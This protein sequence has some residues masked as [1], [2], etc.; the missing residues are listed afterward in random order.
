MN[1]LGNDLL[2]PRRPQL[3]DFQ[4]DI[5]QEGD[6][7]M[8]DQNN[9]NQNILPNLFDIFSNLIPQL[10]IPLLASVMYVSVRHDSSLTQK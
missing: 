7:N 9:M 2:P 1:E 3:N 4:I 10:S 8:D 5:G 6:Q